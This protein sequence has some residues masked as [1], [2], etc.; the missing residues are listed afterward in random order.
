MDS[1]YIKYIRI[2]AREQLLVAVSERHMYA[3]TSLCHISTN[4]FVPTTHLSFLTTLV[5][6]TGRRNLSFE[7]TKNTK[8]S[9]TFVRDDRLGLSR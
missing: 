7:R 4:K 5:I 1:N 2:N 6:S 9:L 8:R 3:Q